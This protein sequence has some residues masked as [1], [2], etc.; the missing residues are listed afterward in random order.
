MNLLI[1]STQLFTLNG[2]NLTINNDFKW[3]VGCNTSSNRQRNSTDT[4]ELFVYNTLNISFTQPT[5]ANNSIISNNSILINVTTRGRVLNYT[6][7][8]TGVNETVTFNNTLNLLINKTGL[9]DLR[10]YHFRVYVND[11][12]GNWN[13]TEYRNIS[14][15]LIGLTVDVSGGVSFSFRGPILRT[16]AFNG[17]DS[18]N[19]A[20]NNTAINL[21][22]THVSR[23][24][25]LYNNGT[26]VN[27]NNYT[28]DLVNGLI[29][30]INLTGGATGENNASWITDKLNFSYNYFTGDSF[31]LLTVSLM[32]RK[33]LSI[34]SVKL[35]VK[36]N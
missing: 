11:S 31:V 36:L 6:L 27:S 13:Y 1:T 25:T 22:R 19:W 26:I 21:G 8:W 16:E 15:N 7:E 14:T 24:F 34:V 17:N 32:K 23:N 10:A 35:A 2:T 30:I 5:V 12:N 18:L 28:I 4:F 20:G 9:D 3:T 29:T 33:H